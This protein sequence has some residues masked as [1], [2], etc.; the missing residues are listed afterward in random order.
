MASSPVVVQSPGNDE[1]ANSAR[2]IEQPHSIV[3]RRHVL[4]D[5]ARCATSCEKATTFSNWNTR[6]GDYWT[7]RGRNSRRSTPSVSYTTAKPALLDH[8]KNLNPCNCFNPGIGHTSKLKRWIS[9]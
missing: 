4:T 3:G 9:P 7:R 5:P 1:T 6:C 8:Y 2:F